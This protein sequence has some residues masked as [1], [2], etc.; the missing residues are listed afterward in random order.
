MKSLACV[1]LLC[2]ALTGCLGPTGSELD[3]DDLADVPVAIQINHFIQ[4]PGRFELEVS[5]Y[6][7]TPGDNAAKRSDCL[8][9]HASATVT[10]NS[11]AATMDWQGSFDDGDAGFET[12]CADPVFSIELGTA[13]DQV[14]IELADPTQTLAIRLAR[15]PDG[16]YAVASCEAAS[17]EMLQNVACKTNPSGVCIPQ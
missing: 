17:C 10:V 15:Q 5:R 4:T 3:E 13:P 8:R 12:N 1:S 7:H 11:A 9:I 16:A 6:G 14:A 2:A